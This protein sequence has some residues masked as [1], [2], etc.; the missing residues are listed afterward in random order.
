[1]DGEVD[2]GDSGR[3]GGPEGKGRGGKGGGGGGRRLRVVCNASILLR[4]KE[5]QPVSFFPSS[6]LLGILRNTS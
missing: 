3:S 5:T 1:M 6:F 2:E 4:C